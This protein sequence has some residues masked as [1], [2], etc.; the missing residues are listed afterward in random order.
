MGVTKGYV[1]RCSE[2][3]LVVCRQCC[4]HSVL[5][6]LCFPQSHSVVTGGLTS[7]FVDLHIFSSLH[8]LC[9]VIGV[10]FSF[11]FFFFFLCDHS[12]HD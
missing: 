10:L 11:S 1:P 3:A 6:C 8:H 7:P 5:A 4:G 2:N 12:Y 9:S